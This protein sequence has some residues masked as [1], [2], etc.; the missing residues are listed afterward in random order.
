MERIHVFTFRTVNYLLD[1]V[2]LA[3]AF[4][5]GLLL[6]FLIKHDGVLFPPVSRNEWTYFGMLGLLFYGT[7]FI[8]LAYYKAYHSSRLRS[9]SS[10]MTIYLRAV[11]MALLLSVLILF[12]FPFTRA[13]PNYTPF[14]NRLGI[15]PF[16]SQ[17]ANLPSRPWFCA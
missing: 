17:R 5:L 16:S 7:N 13:E 9:L 12:L 10:T 2:I 4:S 15:L 6:W 3:L 14:R 11:G 8:C 1:V